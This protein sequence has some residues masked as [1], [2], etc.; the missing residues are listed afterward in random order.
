M[1]LSD[2]MK[3]ITD[4]EKQKEN[5]KIINEEKKQKRSYNKECKDILN[6]IEKDYKYILEQIENNASLGKNEYILKDGSYHPYRQELIRKKLIEEGFKI[7]YIDEPIYD[8]SG[9][10]YACDYLYSIISW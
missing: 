5:R 3:Q 2:K 8:S 4:K 7:K 9:V 6:N 1:K 10:M